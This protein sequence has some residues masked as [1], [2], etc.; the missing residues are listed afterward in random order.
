VRA[1]AAFLHPEIGSGGLYAPI[2]NSTARTPL[3]SAP[4]FATAWEHPTPARAQEWGRR[5]WDV[6]DARV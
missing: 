2:L 4:C 3:P 6:S 5:V 1:P